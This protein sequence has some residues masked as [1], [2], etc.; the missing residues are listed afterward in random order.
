MKNINSV[1]KKGMKKHVTTYIKKLNE[2]P[3]GVIYIRNCNWFLRHLNLKNDEIK[4]DVLIETYKSGRHKMFTDVLKY[5]PRQEIIFDKKKQCF[6]I[7]DLE[8]LRAEWRKSHPEEVI[9]DDVFE[10][11]IMEAERL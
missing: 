3:I 1:R 9:E 6:T 8:K 10:M 4:I 11:F 2:K 7:K 5:G